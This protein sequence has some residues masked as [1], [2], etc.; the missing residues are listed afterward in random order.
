MS[1]KFHIIV[2]IETDIDVGEEEM[3]NMRLTVAHRL[4]G[5]QTENPDYLGNYTTVL[6]IKDIE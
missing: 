3:L 5:Y 1:K 4:Q 6:K 2:E